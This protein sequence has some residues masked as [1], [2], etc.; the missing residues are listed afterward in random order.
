[1]LTMI[2]IIKQIIITYPNNTLL[3]LFLFSTMPLISTIYVSSVFYNSCDIQHMKCVCKQNNGYGTEVILN[4]IKNLY[5]SYFNQIESRMMMKRGLKSK[6]IN[7]QEYKKHKKS[8]A[9]K[10]LLKLISSFFYFT[11]TLT[12][13]DVKLY[14]ELENS[15][16]KKIVILRS[17]DSCHF[18]V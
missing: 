17:N 7:F 18:N 4:L 9:T 15:S 11:H 1:M 6:I 16:Q 8:I 2:K 14:R 12:V 13:M 10:I 5:M 3:S